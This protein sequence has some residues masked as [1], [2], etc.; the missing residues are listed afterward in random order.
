M[1]TTPARRSAEDLEDAVAD[2][3]SRVAFN[4][5]RM[6]KAR[7]WRICDLAAR[8]GLDQNTVNKVELEGGYRFDVL[9]R[10]AAGLGVEA[11]DLFAAP[12]ASV[13]DRAARWKTAAK[14]ARY[15]ASRFALRKLAS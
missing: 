9:C 2:A 4:V 10:V 1:K 15:R 8:A 6:R 11:G 5:K 14:R 12:G 7:R 3:R 13:W